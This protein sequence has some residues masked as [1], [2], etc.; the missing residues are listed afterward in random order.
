MYYYSMQPAQELDIHRLFDSYKQN[1]DICL[2]I[3]TAGIDNAY[4]S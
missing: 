4:H 3:I 1:N 2:C